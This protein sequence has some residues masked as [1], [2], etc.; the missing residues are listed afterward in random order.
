MNDAFEKNMALIAGANDQK[1]Q[2]KTLSDA[3]KKKI[4]SAYM[5]LFYLCNVLTLILCLPQSMV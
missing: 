5:K 1:K 3:D 2:E 4:S